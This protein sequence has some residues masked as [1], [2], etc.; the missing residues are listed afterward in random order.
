MYSPL[1]FFFVIGVI[2]IIIG[3]FFIIR[4]IVFAAMGSGDGNIQ[5]VILSAM[6]IMVGVQCVLAGLQADVIAANRKILEDVQYR[7]KKLEHKDTEDDKL[8]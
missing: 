5:S 6:L 7:V 8:K 3:L 4:F 1:K 2:P